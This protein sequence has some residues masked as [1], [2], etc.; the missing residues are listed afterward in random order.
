MVSIISGRNFGLKRSE[1]SR[2][3]PGFFLNLV[4]NFMILLSNTCILY[5]FIFWYL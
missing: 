3:S 2:L 1:A 5:F 4:N